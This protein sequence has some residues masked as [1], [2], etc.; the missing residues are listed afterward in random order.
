MGLIYTSLLL[1][2]G[3]LFLKG[4]N[5]SFFLLALAR[6]IQALTQQKPFCRIRGRLLLPYFP[7]HSLLR[8]VFG[9]VSYSPALRVEKNEPE[10]KAAAL[11]LVQGRPGTFR[12]ATQR[13]DKLFP[14]TSLALNRRLGIFLEEQTSLRYV[15]QAQLILHV[16]INQEGAYLFTEVIPCLGGLPVG[17]EGNV[18]LL[19]ENEASILAGILMM[20]RG[21]SLVPVSLAGGQDISLLQM[22]SPLPL[23]C[24]LASSLAAIATLPKEKNALALVKGDSF[25]NFSAILSPLPVLRPLIGYDQKMIRKMLEGYAH[26]SI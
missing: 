19:L 4:K 18:L 1:R 13:S 10:I 20:K 23:E 9:L 22:F 15:P 6:N 5:Y 21:C 8:R 25:D 24:A 12:I 14:L 16:E 7:A 3:E 17:V 11:K 26:T 2:P